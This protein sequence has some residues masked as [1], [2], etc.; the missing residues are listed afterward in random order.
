MGSGVERMDAECEEEKPGERGGDVGREER[1]LYALLSEPGTKL[2]S[3]ESA[4]RHQPPA[5]T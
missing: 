2:K 3:Q 1:E 4:T 5:R